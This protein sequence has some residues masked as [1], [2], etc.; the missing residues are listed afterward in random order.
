M[1]ERIVKAVYP[2]PFAERLL[3]LTSPAC[4]AAFDLLADAFRHLDEGATARLNYNFKLALP[5]L[6]E[7]ERQDLIK[8]HWRARFQSELER[9]QLNGMPR[10]RLLEYCRTR[11]EVEGAENLRAACESPQPV[12]FFTPHYGSFVVAVMRVMM[13]VEQHKTL[14]LFYDPP[15]VNPTTTIYQGLIERLS[16]NTKIL[17]NDKTAVLKGLRALK[18]GNAL[19]IMPD[20]Y[21]FNMGMMYVPFFGRLAVAMGGTAFFALKA[22]AMLIP[23]Y[24]WR[25]ARGQFI[26]KYGAPVEPVRT[27]NLNEELYL[28]TAKIF[29]RIEEQLTAAPEHWI[30]WESLHERFSYGGNVAL[31]H[32]TASWESQFTKLRAELAE[33]KSSLGRFLAAFEARL[34]REGQAGDASLRQRT[35]TG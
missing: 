16:C 4:T 11:V 33:E 22:N 1:K 15:E 23:L 18:N 7:T 32:D 28:T 31:P 17:F 24:C 8:R 34:R 29:K 35:G 21:D 19:G 26:L 12:I 6:S 25:R 2:S 14:S 5:Q 30:Y 10:G 27:G 9:I 3:R 20:V 13:D